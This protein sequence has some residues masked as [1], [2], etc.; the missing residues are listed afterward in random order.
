M[1]SLVVV[2]LSVI[3]LAWAISGLRAITN[4]RT[5]GRFGR[6]IEGKEAI[7]IGWIR[8]IAVTVSLLAILICL[9]H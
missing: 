2:I 9:V 3:H 8:I 6:V 1:T 4:R 7:F 5:L